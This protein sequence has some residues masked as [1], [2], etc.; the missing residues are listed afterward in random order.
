MASLDM[1]ICRVKFKDLELTIDWTRSFIRKAAGMMRERGIKPEM[2]I[3]NNS[4]ME[5][6]YGLIDEGLLT[7][8]YYVS[9]VLGMHR[10]NQGATSFSPKHLMHYVD[11]LPPD[12]LFSAL[13][14]G[15]DQ[16]PA[17]TLAI[18][19]GGNARVGFEDNIYY[20]RGELATSNA[21]LVERA[22]EWVRALGHEVATPAEAREMLS[23]TS[24]R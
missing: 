18:V 8:P 3:Y 20:R 6:V 16:L 10:V 21:Q 7:K 22:A 11:L 2:E 9:F 14:I 13:G 15:G 12:C 17:T 24:L 23:I 1:G 5:D 4:N 19:L